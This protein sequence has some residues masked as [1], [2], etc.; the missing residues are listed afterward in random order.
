M[1]GHRDQLKRTF[2]LARM[3]VLLDEGSKHIDNM[4]SVIAAAPVVIRA[5]L[6]LA[7]DHG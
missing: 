2:F 4:M 5:D 6:G 1:D 7:H 3:G